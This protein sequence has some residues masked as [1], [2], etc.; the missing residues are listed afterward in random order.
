MLESAIAASSS[1]T[2]PAS[3]APAGEGRLTRGRGSVSGNLAAMTEGSM[4]ASNLS[5]T[6]AAAQMLSGV[7]SGPVS[8]SQVI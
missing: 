6:D 2:E 3:S 1:L 7:S 8:N 5:I 4:Q